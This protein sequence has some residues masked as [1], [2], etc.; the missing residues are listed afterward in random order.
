M[1][2]I[3][4]LC[5]AVLVLTATGCSPVPSSSQSKNVLKAEVQEAISIFKAKDPSIERFFN[6]SYG[7]AVLPKIF[8]GGFFIGGAH[9]RGEVHE[10]GKMVGFCNMTQGTLG[11]SFGG[12]FFR[13]IIFFRDKPDLDKFKAEEFVFTAQASALAISAGVAAKAD[14][15]DGMAVFIMTDAGLMIDASIGGQQFKYSPVMQ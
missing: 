9:G 6:Q 10:H 15:K 5:L 3:S 1:K 12:E 11:F 7:Y 8:K 4:A 14:Y 13:E 2:A